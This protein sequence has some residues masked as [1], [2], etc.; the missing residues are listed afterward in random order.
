MK[1]IV[2]EASIRAEKYLRKVA[3]EEG[4]AIYDNEK[5]SNIFLTGEDEHTLEL[6][7]EEI[8]RDLYEGFDYDAIYLE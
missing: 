8:K 3:E 6:L 5:D 7:E 1:L 4:L 2:T